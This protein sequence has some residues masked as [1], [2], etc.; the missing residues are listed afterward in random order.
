MTEARRDVRR[1]P[2]WVE[3]EE[4]GWAVVVVVVEGESF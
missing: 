3:E 1:F 4:L 2:E